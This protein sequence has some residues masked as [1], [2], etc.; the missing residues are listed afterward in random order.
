MSQASNRAA[1]EV[2]RE[3]LSIADLLEEPKLAQ[4]YAYLAREGESTVRELMEALD[5]PQGT[6]YTYVNQLTD[7]GV[8]E[9]TSTEQPRTYT[10]REIELTLTG[11]NTEQQ[12]TIT[13][14]LIDA[15][16]R[17]TTDDDIDTYIDRHGVGGLA[18]ALVYT[19]ERERGNVTHRVMANDLDISPLAAE[20]VLQALRPVVTEHFDTESGGVSLVELG[21]E[22]GEPDDEL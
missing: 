1:G 5:L 14:A 16:G 13:P 2:V 11:A 12:Y 7:A 10:V 22:L 15:V 19:V 8:L 21:E 18:T 20:I 6:A 3:F 17:R 4:I 9:S